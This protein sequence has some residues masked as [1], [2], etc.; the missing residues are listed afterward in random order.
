MNVLDVGCGMGTLM[1]E[2]RSSGAQV[3][4]IE[5][6]PDRARAC[7][8]AGLPVT[9]GKGERLPFA[10]ASFDA[11]VCS[12][13]LPYTDERQAVAELG[14]VLR[15]GG[16]AS[17]TCHGIGYGLYYVG[18]GPGWR[19]RFYGVRM[20]ANTAVYRTTG[21]R[22]PGFLGDTLCQTPRRLAKYI[23][24]AGL[25]VETSGTIEAAMGIPRFLCIRARK[26]AIA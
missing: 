16:F 22:L 25:V 24:E 8:E 6:D 4:G 26:R 5:P 18:H 23:R 10:D 7:T 3:L 9:V 1:R 2:L 20:L 15:P 12:V 17:V 14:R 13:V 19:R 21:S 11:A